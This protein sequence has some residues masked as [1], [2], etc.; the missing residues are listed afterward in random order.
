MG[1]PSDRSARGRLAIWNVALG[2]IRER[3]GFGSGVGSYAIRQKNAMTSNLAQYRP[4]NTEAKNLYL[5]LL[6]EVGFLGGGLYFLAAVT[7]CTLSHHRLP[8]ID[9]SKKV[10]WI[11]GIQAGL[12]GMLVAGLTDTPVLA[13][14][15]YPCTVAMAALVG[16]STR[17]LVLERARGIPGEIGDV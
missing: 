9:D 17:L 7:Y 11:T 3:P 15:R 12:V 2:L 8:Q 10:A 6:V 1:N 5:T 4:H 16:L 13:G 14:G